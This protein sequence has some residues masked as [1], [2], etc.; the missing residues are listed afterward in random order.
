MGALVNWSRETISLKAKNEA[1]DIGLRNEELSPFEASYRHPSF[2]PFH[3]HCTQ[4]LQAV[5]LSHLYQSKEL[6]RLDPETSDVSFLKTMNLGWRN[7]LHT[8]AQAHDLSLNPKKT[9]K[10]PSV[11]S[12]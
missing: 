12:V 4:T 7:D 5:F 6:G 10:Q 1:D 3:S 9:H 8:Y 11:E 2:L